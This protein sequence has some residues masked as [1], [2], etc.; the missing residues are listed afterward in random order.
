MAEAMTP[1][2]LDAELIS[3]IRFIDDPSV[4][5]AH[6]DPSIEVNGTEIVEYTRLPVT[7]RTK[8]AVAVWISIAG[9][10]STH[11]SDDRLVAGLRAAEMVAG[12]FPAAIR[13]N[14]C[15][16]DGTSGRRLSFDVVRD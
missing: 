9:T 7:R 12:E 5:P 14:F 13:V 16:R 2:P 15:M 4:G 3:T 8:A 1:S 6:Q 11:S 10:D